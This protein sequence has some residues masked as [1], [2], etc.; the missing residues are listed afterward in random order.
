MT[1]VLD[2]SLH[3]DV[4]CQNRDQVV[5]ERGGHL[6]YRNLSSSDLRWNGKYM[7]ILPTTRLAEQ[8]YN[9]GTSHRLALPGALQRSLFSLFGL[10]PAGYRCDLDSISSVS[11][12]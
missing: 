4:F 3:L 8:R 5:L 11:G 6:M 9:A 7:L 2:S 12:T 10:M 1:F